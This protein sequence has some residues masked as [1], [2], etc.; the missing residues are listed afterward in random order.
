MKSR[1]KK[2]N[3]WSKIKEKNNIKGRHFRYR[4]TT[5]NS[6]YEASI[7]LI[8]KLDKDIRKKLQINIFHEHTC[9]HPQ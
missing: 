2:I 5:P 9:K 4:G 3:D 8:S 6:F 1:G 7:T